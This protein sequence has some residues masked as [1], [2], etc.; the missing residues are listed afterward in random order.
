MNE[1]KKKITK[2]DDDVS[3]KR[4]ERFFR[5]YIFNFQ[6]EG[7]NQFRVLPDCSKTVAAAVAQAGGKT[8]K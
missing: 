6:L 8:R 4:C 1:R 5:D 3:K 2:R 7:R